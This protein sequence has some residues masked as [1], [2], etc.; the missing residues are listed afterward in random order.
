MPLMQSTTHAPQMPLV[1]STTHAP[2]MNFA[3]CSIVIYQGNSAPAVPPLPPRPV[4][5]A[6]GQPTVSDHELDD[7]DLDMFVSDF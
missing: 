3:G 5:A 4:V 7:L 6:H 1:Q 2:Q